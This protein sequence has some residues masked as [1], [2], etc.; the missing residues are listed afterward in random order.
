MGAI[1]RVFRVT[2]SEG[3]HVALKVVQGASACAELRRQYELTRKMPAAAETY[4]VSVIPGSLREA[5]LERDPFVPLLVAAFLMPTVGHPLE[6]VEDITRP[7]ALEVLNA[8]S[9]LHALSVAHGDARWKNVVYVENVGWKW[10]DLRTQQHASSVSYEED[11][12]T[13]L[14]SCGRNVSPTAV[15]N[16]AR[17]AAQGWGSVEGRLAAIEALL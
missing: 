11:V 12:C 9:L 10:I 6:H 2:T 7:V 4:A 14:T 1:G 13:F 5:S 15:R 8:L 17:G 16:Y 3:T